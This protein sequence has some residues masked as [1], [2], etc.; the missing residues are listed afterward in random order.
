MLLQIKTL[1]NEKF[2]IECE[3]S[4]SVRT[5]KE[6]IASKDLKDKYEADAVKLIF[7]GKILEDSKTLE[8]YS[9][10]Q[11]SFLVVVKQAP[12]KASA[13]STG[14]TSVPSNPPRPASPQ[15]RA[16]NVPPPASS[17]V[18]QQQQQQQQQPPRTTP[19]DSTSAASQDTFLSAEARE[20][21]LRELT[22]MGFDRT[23]ADLALRASFY[24][25]ERAAEYLITGNIPILNEGPASSQGG[26]SGQTPTGS[27]S[28]AGGRRPGGADDLSELSQ[29]PQFQALRNLIQQNP[30]QLQTLMQTL[31][32]TQ[33]DLYR[34]IE[35]RPQEFLELLNQAD[36]LD[37]GGDDDDPLQGGAAGG[38][39]GQGPPGTVTI[40][41]SP[42]D[43]QAINRLQDMGFERNRVIEA[44]L[45]CDRNE[46]L[47]ANYLLS[48]FD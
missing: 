44:F 3:L 5:I 35:Q 32:A 8:S 47:A 39:G 46:E 25:V 48:S 34:L 30:D 11:D 9:I 6:K 43:Q 19:T 37:E 41:L 40:T 22:D 31:Q 23:Q 7:S 17:S 12:P 28:S 4:D 21:A 29:N 38:A 15:N 18:S 16:T 14:S 45:A 2:T 13:T 33:P 1:S 27:E 20:K 24:H 10:N 42:Q 26:E 36:E